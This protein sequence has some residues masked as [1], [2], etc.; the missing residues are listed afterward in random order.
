MWII[1]YMCK[2]WRA[3]CALQKNSCL[4]NI[5]RLCRK[6]EWLVFFV[7]RLPDKVEVQLIQNNTEMS[8]EKEGVLL[9]HFMSGQGFWQAIKLAN[10]TKVVDLC[11]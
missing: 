11:W 1:L 6:A 10:F 4:E 8:S 5:Y 9:A 2:N 3:K 7:N